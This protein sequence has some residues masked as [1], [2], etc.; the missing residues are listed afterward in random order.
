MK[1]CTRKIMLIVLTL[2]FS[3][4]IFGC[5]GGGGGSVRGGPGYYDMHYNNPWYGYRGGFPP[6]HYIGPPP[7]EIP[8]DIPDIP[9]IPD[10]PPLEA[11]PLPM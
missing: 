1:Y 8:P 4:L 5:G 10:M 3:A 2:L 11:V 7:I 9:D 6:P